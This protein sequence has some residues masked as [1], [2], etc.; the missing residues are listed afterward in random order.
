MLSL[1]HDYLNVRTKVQRSV[2]EKLLIRK[3]ICM[4]DYSVIKKS[5]LVRMVNG[6]SKTRTI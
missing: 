2:C 1:L 6:K 4:N 3:I 5:M